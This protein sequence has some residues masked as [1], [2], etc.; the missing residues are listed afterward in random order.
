MALIALVGANG[1]PGVTVTALALTYTWPR[2]VILA[3]CDPAGGDIRYG[4]LRQLDMPEDQGLMQVVVAELRS[5]HGREQ[6]WR[7][8]GLV[9]LNPPATQRL[10]L[11]GVTTPAKAP[12]LAPLWDQLAAMF[13]ELEYTNPGYDVIADCG[14]LV[15]PHT[16]WPLLCRADAVAIVARPTARSLVSA[17]AAWHAARTQLRAKGS[18]ERTL[19]LQL[20]GGGDYSPAEIARRFADDQ[21]QLDVLEPLPADE[22][23]AAVL[24][25]GGSLYRRQPLLRAAAAASTAI[26][27][28]AAEHQAR[29]QPAA[30]PQEVTHA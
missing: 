3:E 14:R 15:A 26:R 30:R 6:M 27:R 22:R 19:A 21:S 8:G 18:G 29:L 1:S 25:F 17:H 7:P 23:A 5:G 2:P 28:R 9:N 24:S 13:A 16:P 11:P 20:V 4:Y 10:L 12:S